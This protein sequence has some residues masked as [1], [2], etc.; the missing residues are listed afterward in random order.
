MSIKILDEIASANERAGYI[1]HPLSLEESIRIRN[2]LSAVYLK[3]KSAKI[4]SYQSL[5][6]PSGFRSSAGWSVL[7]VFFGEAELFFFLNPDESQIVWRC[8]STKDLVGLL[9]DSYG[10]PFYVCSIDLDSLFCFDD[11]D[12]VMVA[13]KAAFHVENAKRVLKIHDL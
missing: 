4:F 11:H 9:A 3:E 12:C 2:E 6:D 1:L 8:G 10:Y 7:P 5:R 13:G